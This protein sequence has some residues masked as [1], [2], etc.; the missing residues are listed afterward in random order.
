MK[1][2][3]NARYNTRKRKGCWANDHTKKSNMEFCDDISTLNNANSGDND[4]L[5]NLKNICDNTM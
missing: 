1:F 5:N 2:G 4:D 3:T